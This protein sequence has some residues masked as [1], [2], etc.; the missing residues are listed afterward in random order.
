M[1]C[2]EEDKL[3]EMRLAR[4]RELDMMMEARNQA[5]EE[6]ERERRE[7]EAIRRYGGG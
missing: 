4:E 3:E 1:R 2:A 5:F 7:Q 6:E